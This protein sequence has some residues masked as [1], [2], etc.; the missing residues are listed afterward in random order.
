V[1]LAE[2]YGITP[3]QLALAWAKQR[4]CNAN[5]SIIIGTT[6][7]RQAR[8]LTGLDLTGLDLT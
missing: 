8:G 4:P 7:V 1:A 5:G 6:T 2:A 3:T